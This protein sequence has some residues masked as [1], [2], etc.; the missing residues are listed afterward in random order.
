MR[1]QEVECLWR[2]AGPHVPVQGVV[3]KVEGYR[4]RLTLVRSATDLTGLQLVELFCARFRQEDGFRDRKQRLGWE[5]CR[6]WTQ[7]PIERTTQAPLLVL[8]L[9]RLLPCRLEEAAGDTWW[10]HPPWNQR[11]ARPRVLDL[12]RLLGQHRAAI[13]QLLS[14]WLGT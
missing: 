8:T 13:R 10:V 7:L 11:K 2:V 5:E 1:Y 12:E 6:A 3:A 14:A 9:R 4:K